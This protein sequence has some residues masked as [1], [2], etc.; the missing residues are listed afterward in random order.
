MR[1]FQQGFTLIELLV[2]LF[3]F[4]ILAM[5]TAGI[6]HSVLQTQE[7]LQITDKALTQIQLTD[8]ILRHDMTEIINQPLVNHLGATEP[9]VIG[10]YHE[11]SFN[12]QAFNT[13]QNMNHLPLIQRA[14][15]KQIGNRVVEVIDIGKKNKLKRELLTNVQSISFGYMD[16]TLGFRQNWFDTTNLPKAIQIQVT[17]QNQNTL[18]WLIALPTSQILQINTNE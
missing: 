2:A 3:I 1:L 6:L 16:N 15:I 4:A 17:L 14:I 12:F 9:A 7:R 13:N 11:C 18:T 5:I 10:L 8:S